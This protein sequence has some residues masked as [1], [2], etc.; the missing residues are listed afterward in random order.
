M[1]RNI[2]FRFILLSLLSVGLNVF[3]SCQK[4]IIRKE[5]ARMIDS[6]ISIP[7][8]HYAIFNGKDTVM[9]IAEDVN[10]KMIVFFDST[11][12]SSCHYPDMAFW[13]EVISYSKATQLQFEPI[14][15]FSPR[16]E[17]INLLKQNLIQSMF[18]WP[19]FIDESGTFIK[20]NSIIPQDRRFHTFLLDYD[21]KI[22]LV[23]NPINN[24]DLWS[25]YKEQILSRIIH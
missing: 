2:I 10:V 11:F 13:G 3:F 14:F 15:I 23:G 7:H 22:I 6:E 8:L 19:L 21:N 9:H 5:L 18:E 4:R 17:D 1:Y 16:K 12:C 20:I 24:D 25:M